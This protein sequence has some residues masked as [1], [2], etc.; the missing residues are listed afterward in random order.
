VNDRLVWKNAMTGWHGLSASPIYSWPIS[1]HE[2]AR[3]ANLHEPQASS[4]P[5]GF[6]AATCVVPGCKREMTQMWHLWLNAGGL[7]KEIHMCHRCAT[8]IYGAPVPDGI[9]WEDA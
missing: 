1:Q 8:D 2:R 3:L 9:L 6:R 5:D 4:S 7:K